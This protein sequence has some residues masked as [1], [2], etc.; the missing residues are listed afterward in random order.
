VTPVTA[1]ACDPTYR[2]SMPELSA[3]TRA[4]PKSNMWRSGV[5]HET[6]RWSSPRT[7][8]TVGWGVWLLPQWE[9]HSTR[10]GVEHAPPAAPPTAGSPG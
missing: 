3:R 2:G 9:K 7:L 5:W 1:T 4:S 6:C 10:W 8:D